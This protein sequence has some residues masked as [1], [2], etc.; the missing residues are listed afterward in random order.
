MNKLASC[1]LCGSKN[2]TLVHKGVRDGDTIN[3]LR[4]KECG[5]VRLSE[6]MDDPDLWESLKTHG[7]SILAWH[8]EPI[9]TNGVYC[10]ADGPL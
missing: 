8:N 10:Y 1:F 2:S 6:I 5:L 7:I 9:K 3:V 4:C